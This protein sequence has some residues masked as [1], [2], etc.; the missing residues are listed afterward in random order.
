MEASRSYEALCPDDQRPLSFDN[1]AWYTKGE[2]ARRRIRVSC[3]AAR[4]TEQEVLGDERFEN[5]KY[6]QY[7][8]SGGIV[9]TWVNVDGK[10]QVS[11]LGRVR[12]VRG[13]NGVFHYTKGR[14]DGSG[15]YHASIH[16]F[17]TDRSAMVHVLVKHTFHGFPDDLGL[18]P[19]NTNVDHRTRDRANNALDNLAYANYSQQSLNRGVV[20][21]TYGVDRFEDLPGDV[22]EQAE[23]YV[24][25]RPDE[26]RTRLEERAAARLSDAALPT[27]QMFLRGKS[28]C[29]LT[30]T[31]LRTAQSYIGESMFGFEYHDLEGVFEESDWVY[32][33]LVVELVAVEHVAAD[34]L[35]DPRRAPV[36][37]IRDG[38]L[39]PLSLDRVEKR[40]SLLDRH[41]LRRAPN[42]L[43]IGSENLSGP[44]A[45]V[46]P[47]FPVRR[48]NR[49]FCASGVVW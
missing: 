36:A 7:D 49:G 21:R 12:Y 26:S 22:L 27:M 46:A 19:R 44:R 5:V 48:T 16:R 18:D 42:D 11:T 25:P 40:L 34:D 32:P 31:E 37:G 10:F 38:A 13:D 17:A 33:H 2:T 1:I 23:Q 45:L 47:P 41:P 30:T 29:D 9:N 35:G 28:L 14:V 43:Q 39:P 20:L 4:D 24:R 8:M 6:R 15:Y 3:E